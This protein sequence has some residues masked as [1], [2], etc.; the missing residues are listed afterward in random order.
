MSVPNETARPLIVQTWRVSVDT[1]LF[2]VEVFDDGSWRP[3]Y[4]TPKRLGGWSIEVLPDMPPTADVERAERTW[5]R[6]Y[7]AH[8]SIRRTPVYPPATSR[9]TSFRS[10]L[11]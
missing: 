1:A 9:N 10:R 3:A 2:L 7:G 4:I 11:E 5:A 8:V 6:Q